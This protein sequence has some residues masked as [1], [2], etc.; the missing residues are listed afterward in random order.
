MANNV[1]K[2]AGRQEVIA[3]KQKITFGT[4][5]MIDSLGAVG[6]IDLPAGAVVLSGW[7]NVKTAT[8]ATATLA[9]GDSGNATRY[10][11]ATSIAAVA[12]TNLTTTGFQHPAAVTLLATI[13]TAAPVLAG[14]A[15]IIVEYVVEG[16]AAFSQG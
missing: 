9:L 1:V 3:V 13:A 2:N 10:L 7:L 11:A 14:E 5:N 12:K 8:T 6:V 16:R 4:G 15:E